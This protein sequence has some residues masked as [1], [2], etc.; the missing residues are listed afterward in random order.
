MKKTVRL[1]LIAMTVVAMLTACFSAVLADDDMPQEPILEVP[2]TEETPQE[3]EQQQEQNQE[4]ALFPVGYA[5]AEQN[6]RL[7]GYVDTDGD[8]TAERVHFG[9]VH[10]GSYLYV[11]RVLGS[12][13]WAEVVL[14]ANTP[15]GVLPVTGQARTSELTPAETCGE[16]VMQYEGHGLSLA[17]FEAR[18]FEVKTPDEEEVTSNSETVTV[19]D[20]DG[21]DNT[22]PT[23]DDNND[24]DN[25][26]DTDIDPDPDPDTDT[27]TDTDNDPN[28]DTDPDNNDNNETTETPTEPTVLL[29]LENTGD[30]YFGDTVTL[31]LIVKDLNQEFT[32]RWQVWKHETDE[33]IWYDI[34]GVTGVT[35]S[36][37]V[38]EE[39]VNYEYRVV[40]TVQDDE[41]QNNE[42]DEQNET[43]ID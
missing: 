14:A 15:D 42:E 8:G 33:E 22:E 12:G 1:L 34:D 24:P 20:T 21:D 40:L 31:Q 11:T 25:D 38:T 18:E 28:T 13:A 2:Q 4:P 39:N 41:N 37:V 27:D 6:V 9:T 32:I 43:V 10:A 30:I 35:Y 16:V 17:V 19:S 36:F 7:Y 26:N 29:V 5:Y 23:N 3:Q